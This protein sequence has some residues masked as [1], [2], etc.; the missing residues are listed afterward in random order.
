VAVLYFARDVFIPLALAMLLAFL[1]E[2]LVRRLESWHLG[3]TAS[4]MLGILTLAIA[5]SVLGLV[6]SRQLSQLSGN[7]PQ[8][9]DNIHKRLQQIRKANIGFAERALRSIQNFPKE[10]TP[11]NSSPSNLSSTNSPPQAMEKPIPVEIHNGNQTV[12]KMVQPYIS[13][14][15]SILLKL[16]LVVVFCIFMLLE[17]DDLRARLIRV[18]GPRNEKLTLRLLVEADNRLSRFLLMQAA[19]NV[20]YGTAVALALWAIGLPIPVLWGVSAAL[21]RYIPYAGPWIGASLPF[22]VALAIDSGWSEPLMVLG[23]FVI[24]E[25]VTA[26]FAEPWLYGRSIGITPFAVL[27]AAVFWTWLWG[28]VGLLLSMPLTVTLASIARYF[29]QLEIIDL[30]FGKAWGPRR[31]SPGG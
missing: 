20:C 27:L 8:Y 21:F 26:N 16:L 18:A 24:L 23:V 17:R 12:L 15:L 19:V 3:R 11:T 6:V 31:K 28:P 14:S 25:I 13:P 29:P 7:L 30:L 2:P 10:L 9:R 22:A 4:V 5:F 1:L